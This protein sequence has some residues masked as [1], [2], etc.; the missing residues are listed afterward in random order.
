MAI[1]SKRLRSSFIGMVLLGYGGLCVAQ[2]SESICGEL[3]N[4]FGPYDYR[5]DHYKQ[6][7]GDQM[8]L[9]VKKP[10]VEGA[11]F[12]RR[13][14]TLVGNQSAGQ[15]GPAGPDLDYT[16]RAFPNHPRALISVMRYGEKYNS[17]TPPGL[18]YIVECYFERAIR[19]QP[20]DVMA[21][22]IYAE[23]LKRKNRAPEAARQLEQVENLA[24]Q[25]FTFYN[26]GML[27]FDLKMYEASARALQQAI[28]LGFERPGLD[29]KLKGVG[30]WPP[31]PAGPASTASASSAASAASEPPQ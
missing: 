10:L 5:S 8:P 31:A 15:V 28:S 2:V 16:L 24:D 19:F 9:S 1:R 17:E 6:P 11:H 25:G 4:A 7:P 30:A 3:A 27:Y 21:R 29:G 20:D 13:V 14:E 12:T 18:R 22:M 26:V 23:F